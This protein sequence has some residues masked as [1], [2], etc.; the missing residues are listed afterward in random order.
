MA[1]SLLNAMAACHR[2]LITHF[3]PE[4]CESFHL[5]SPSKSRIL[6]LGGSRSYVRHGVRK[7]TDDKS[8]IDCLPDPC[9]DY[10]RICAE[11]E[12]HRSLEAMWAGD[13]HAHSTTKWIGSNLS[14]VLL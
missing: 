12:Q 3:G 6:S 11:I 7:G 5:R 13:D 4:P 10:R 8:L 9:G 1:V 2:T 14:L